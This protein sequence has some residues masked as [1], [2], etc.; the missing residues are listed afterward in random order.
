MPKISVIIP[1]YNHAKYLPEALDSILNQTYKAFEIIVVD[2]GSTDNTKEI[3]ARYRDKI[4][5]AYQQNGK[6]AKARNTGITISSGEYIAFL[7]ADDVWMPEMLELQVRLLDQNPGIGLVFADAEV[8]RD[9]ITKETSFWLTRRFG[10]ELVACT[11]EVPDAFQRLIEKNF[12]PT[13][14]VVVRRV[15]FDT[16]GFFDES[17]PPA[18]DKDMWL[19]I[20]RRFKIKCNPQILLRKR[21]YSTSDSEVVKRQVLRVLSKMQILYPEIIASMEAVYNRTCARLHADLAAD[22][23]YRDDLR[24]ARQECVASLRYHITLRVLGLGVKTLAG[25]RGKMVLRRL[26]RLAN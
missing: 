7:D 6:Q 23:W 14:T 8:F 13:G 17:L 12:I 18:E 20:A 21:G 1:T 2:D 4:R 26:R 9:E 24:R 25:K 11:D 16:V 5:Y 3:V 19:R 15:C 22:Y 10:D